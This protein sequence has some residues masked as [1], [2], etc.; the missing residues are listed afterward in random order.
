VLTAETGS[1]LLRGILVAALLLPACGPAPPPSSS[2]AGQPPLPALVAS[3]PSPL[4]AAPLA[5]PAGPPDDGPP[6]QPPMALR[7]DASLPSVAG[8]AWRRQH[9]TLE[10]DGGARW[11]SE[12]GGGEGDVDEALVE[13]PRPAGSSERCAGRLGPAL[14]RRIVEAARRAMASGCKQR[15]TKIDAVST[16][17]EVTWDGGTSA[18]SVERVGG[19]Y[20]AFE[21]ARAQVVERLCRR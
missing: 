3:A 20:A 14:H 7:W 18:C 16:T 5:S 2:L 13:G 11:V 12:S 9:L 15:P 10:A 8:R 17:V 4:P 21:E 19:S 6:P 1:A